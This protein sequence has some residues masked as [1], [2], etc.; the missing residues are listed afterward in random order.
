SWEVDPV[1]GEVIDD[2]Y[3]VAY[4]L[5][6]VA[7]DGSLTL[8]AP[9]QLV[10]EE[11]DDFDTD[12]VS[13]LSPTGPVY[14]HIFG[15]QHQGVGFSGQVTETAL[16]TGEVENID[17]AGGAFL[18]PAATTDATASAA[19]NA[20]SSMTGYASALY[21]DL[22]SAPQAQSYLLST[23]TPDNLRSSDALNVLTDKAAGTVA[24]DFGL[25]QAGT[26]P[27]TPFSFGGSA[28]SA[29][30]MPDFWMALDGAG[31]GFA[32]SQRFGY[33][34]W[35]LDASGR[36]LGTMV[37]W[38]SAPHLAL[39][40]WESSVTTQAGF[41]GFPQGLSYFVAGQQKAHTPQ[42]GDD[43]R[44]IGLVAFTVGGGLG[45]EA[46]DG[47]A[48][49]VF[50]GTGHW[51]ADI[52]TDDQVILIGGWIDSLSGSLEGMIKSIN[53][54]D[55][56]SGN[57]Y[58]DWFGDATAT[59]LAGDYGGLYTTDPDAADPDYAAGVV[60][61]RYVKTGTAYAHMGG[62]F[63]G[64]FYD[65]T[66]GV[67]PSPDPRLP[68]GVE[69]TINADVWYEASLS[70]STR[71]GVARV[72]F[73]LKTMMP[74]GSG[75]DMLGARNRVLVFPMEPVRH[76]ATLYSEASLLVDSGSVRMPFMH[77]DM[78]GPTGG[79]PTDAYFEEWEM[80]YLDVPVTVTSDNR[81]EFGIFRMNGNNVNVLAEEYE[82]TEFCYSRQYSDANFTGMGYVGVP[83]NQLGPAPTDGIYFYGNTY[84]E[85]RDGM[86]TRFSDS[87]MVHRRESELDGNLPEDTGQLG[88][89]TIVANFHNNRVMGWR[90]TEDPD[91]PLHEVV[92]AEYF[93]GKIYT[94]DSEF[95]G[96]VF[97]QLAK[98]GGEHVLIGDS[99]GNAPVKGE[100]FGE[101][102]GA[103]HQ[104]VGYTGGGTAVRPD[105]SVARHWNVTGAGFERTTRRV[106]TAP[107]GYLSGP[108][109]V[110][111]L[112]GW[113]I[114]LDNST[115]P[116]LAFNYMADVAYDGVAL[117]FDYDTGYVSGYF[118]CNADLDGSPGGG[119]GFNLS[120][121]GSAANSVWVA[122]GV[123]AA[124]MGNDTAYPNESV[125]NN[126]DFTP[127]Y[128]TLDTAMPNYIVTAPPSMQLQGAEEWLAWGEWSAT[129]MDPTDGAPHH[130]A[131]KLSFWVAGQRTA[132]IGAIP[133]TGSATYSGIAHGAWL[134][135]DGGFERV[136]GSSNLS[137][138][139]SNAMV[140]GAIQ[141]QGPSA[142]HDLNVGA[143]GFGDAGDWM[144]SV[145]N[146]SV[147]NSATLN[148]SYTPSASQ[149]NGAFYGPNDPTDSNMPAAVAGNVAAKSAA[150][151]IA[152]IY[153]AGKD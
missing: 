133:S 83:S 127:T 26:G 116:R 10:V 76:D 74:D 112:T 110:G 107:S 43:W 61:T 113:D 53:S 108:D 138:D 51:Q 3:P 73:P 64:A 80:G 38:N 122:P 36:T 118:D 15:S 17:F 1:S 78:Y 14:G 98:W 49:I 11:Q 22:T 105:A 18:N 86:A 71:D 33:R 141:F 95:D 148:G 89:V 54:D 104:G 103:Q 21:V 47:E 135:P 19:A 90:Y 145:S 72:L 137:V 117:W 114:A 2:V 75:Y 35:G 115:G 45:I 142:T 101:F 92:P 150:G 34:E 136:A 87:Q 134:R 143:S 120:V 48:T 91:C 9:V 63:G 44:G 12:G 106:A 77:W 42:A 65:R 16:Y 88:P 69:R 100:V 139:F 13:Q 25:R 57:L 39:G 5:G 129:Y 79:T 81:G 152:G 4:V 149:F 97:Q 131:R 8:S 50:D 102:Y 32:L 85:A 29:Y 40:R 28:P 56:A 7:T 123:F 23:G 6:T 70:G 68:A 52:T 125:N 128:G 109:F 144:G 66:P 140:S 153:A 82:D 119:V 60:A 84:A 41:G 93:V 62:S 94:A 30:I 67:G 58:A 59:Y 27:E 121:G 37:S 147:T 24:I 20:P 111:F 151:T 130:V 124:E 31:A 99:W 126:P 46:S 55:M 132:D 96:Q 146:W